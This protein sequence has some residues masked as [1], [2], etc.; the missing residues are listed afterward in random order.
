MSIICDR[1][2]NLFINALSNV[3][4]QQSCGTLCCGHRRVSAGKVTRT[5]TR[6]VWLCFF[7]PWLRKH[8]HNVARAFECR[9]AYVYACE[10]IHDVDKYAMGFMLGE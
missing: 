2:S 1:R 7:I 10:F 3:T 4:S 5:L 9:C 8:C 6:I